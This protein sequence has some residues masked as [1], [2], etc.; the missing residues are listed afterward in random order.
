MLPLDH[1]RCFTESSVGFRDHWRGQDVVSA[2]CSAALV[3]ELRPLAITTLRAAPVAVIDSTECLEPAARLLPL[4]L[5]F[6]DHV[7]LEGQRPSDTMGF[8]PRRKNQV[9]HH[10]S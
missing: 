4:Q 8:L 9:Q 5:H 3:M 1:R 6:L 10:S 2:G 7:C